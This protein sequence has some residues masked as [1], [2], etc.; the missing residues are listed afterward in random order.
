MKSNCLFFAFKAWWRWR[1]KRA[2]VAFRKSDH[3]TG[4]HWLVNYKGRWIHFQPRKPKE[5]LA[6]AII[7]K[8]YFEGYISRRD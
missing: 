2:Y 8:L 3:I 1:K 6:K 7:H 5:R 4:L